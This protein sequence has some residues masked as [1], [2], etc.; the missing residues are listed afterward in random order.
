MISFGQEI[1]KSY[2][3]NLRQPQH[4]SVVNILTSVSVYSLQINLVW[5]RLLLFNAALGAVSY[6]YRY[7][8]TFVVNVVAFLRNNIARPD[9]KTCLKLANINVID[10][11]SKTINHKGK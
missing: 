11:L 10:V 7:A 2:S 5:R 1:K 8:R 3:F 4:C 9:P 6:L